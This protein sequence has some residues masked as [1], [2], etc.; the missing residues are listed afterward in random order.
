MQKAGINV[1][2]V[3][4]VNRGLILQNIAT[5]AHPITRGELTAQTGLSKMT[6]SN[7]IGEFLS[8]DLVVEEATNPD[9]PISRSNPILLRI[10]PN[11][12][13]MIG[14]RIRH[15]L[16]MA[17]L[18]DLCLQT[19][20]T[21]RILLEENQSGDALLAAIR[22]LITPF[23]QKHNIIG[24]GVGSI[25]PVVDSE[26][27]VVLSPSDFSGFKSLAIRDYLRRCSHVPVFV[28]HTSS[29]AIMAEQLFGSAKSF[30]DFTYFSMASG[31]NLGVI[32]NAQLQSSRT[33]LSGEIG[34]V[35]I[36][37][38][39]P[40]CYC[41]N[42]G[43]LE[44]FVTVDKLRRDAKASPLINRDLTFAQLCEF[45]EQ[46]AVH[47]HL[48]HGLID[49]LIVAMTNM[50]HLLNPEAIYLGDELVR[51]PARY[52]NYLEQELNNRL[53]S[54][55]YRYIKILRATIPTEDTS[56]FCSITVLNDLFQNGPRL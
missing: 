37:M 17:T 24:I 25:G 47:Q 41:G 34:H 46:P 23:L 53:L 36:S 10:S 52:L 26:Q 55:N 43:C 35:C 12:P 42:R 44:A 29:C 19:L 54:R 40:L 3:K 49:Y 45:S 11:A 32:S 15:H 51:L 20:E 48:M 30:R 7:I 9:A 27:G 14:I 50:A 1:K 16:C 22:D 33:G 6:V 5:A 39:G 8:R 13:K 18:C 28:E 38:D 56:A 21:H 2:D 31:F 4:S